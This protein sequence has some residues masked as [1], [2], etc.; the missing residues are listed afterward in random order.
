MATLRILADHYPVGATRVPLEG[1][2]R[3]VC[4][5]TTMPLPCNPQASCGPVPLML[6]AAPVHANVGRVFARGLWRSGT[7]A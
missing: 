7:L 4:L 5:N 3:S 6:H 2:L 1:V